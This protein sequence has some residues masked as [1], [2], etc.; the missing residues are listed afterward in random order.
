[1]HLE[2][3]NCLIDDQRLAT[4][5]YVVGLGG[6]RDPYIFMGLENMWVNFGRTQAHLP[7]RGPAPKPEV[8]RGTVG[9]TIVDLNKE[10]NSSLQKW[11]PR[12]TTA[13]TRTSC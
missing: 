4:L 3:F 6:T 2:H 5:F 12:R 9:L 10:R 1:M 7:S 13:S 8:L 11:A